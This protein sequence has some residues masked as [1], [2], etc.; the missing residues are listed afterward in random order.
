[1]IHDAIVSGYFALALRKSLKHSGRNH[2]ACFEELLCPS[3]NYQVS[4]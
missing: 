1:M 4:D 2:H 3:T